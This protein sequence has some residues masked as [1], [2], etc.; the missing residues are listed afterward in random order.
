MKRFLIPA[1]VLALLGS[2]VVYGDGTTRDSATLKR[3]ESKTF[4]QDGQTIHVS[5]DG[6]SIDVSIESGGRTRR[7]TIDNGGDGDI[8]IDR[9]GD[10]T[11]TID[12]GSRS[13]RR[14]VVNRGAL[15]DILGRSL[16][17]RRIHADNWFVCP[18]DH[19]LLR[20]PEGKEDQTFTCPIDGTA[21]EKQKS[22]MFVFPGTTFL[23]MDDDL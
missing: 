10:D 1:A 16:P 20:V 18:K 2:G 3:G 4:V 22:R 11:I 13:H 19:T 17:T 14:I 9:D 23:N 8:R 7:I 6:D 21:M 12:P 15:E 5:R